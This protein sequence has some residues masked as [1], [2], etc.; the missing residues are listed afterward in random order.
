[1]SPDATSRRVGKRVLVK[2]LIVAAIPTMPAGHSLDEGKGLAQRN[3]GWD[4]MP[5]HPWIE[6]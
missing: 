3:R 1:M 2:A 4:K 5:K 6:V